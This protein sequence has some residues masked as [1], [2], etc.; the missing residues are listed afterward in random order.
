[1]E[2]HK[3]LATENALLMVIYTISMGSSQERPLPF[4]ALRDH[5]AP[6]LWRGR[7]ENT[8]ALVSLPGSRR[9]TGE[10]VTGE[11]RRGPGRH[12]D[13]KQQRALRWHSIIG[14]TALRAGAVGEDVA[15]L[16]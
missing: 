6:L 11:Q 10:Q 4:S 1:M 7:K 2:K 8:L 12:R 5:P 16:T 3:S 14:R 9:H 15:H 13:E